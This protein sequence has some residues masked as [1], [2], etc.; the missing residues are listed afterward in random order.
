MLQFL[1]RMPRRLLPVVWLVTLLVASGAATPRLRAVHRDRVARA[2][3]QRTSGTRAGERER[4]IAPDP[5]HVTLASRGVAGGEPRGPRRLA[6][7]VPPRAGLTA[8]TVTAS[9]DA[10]DALVSAARWLA[11]PHPA[12][13]PPA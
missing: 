6:A 2:S 3:A 9:V 8:P 4:S 12:R 10:S 7:I 13:G 1:A 5:D 11:R